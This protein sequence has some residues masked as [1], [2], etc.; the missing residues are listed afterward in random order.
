MQP[1]FILNNRPY[2]C[3]T[4]IGAENRQKR[5]DN[6]ILCLSR[7]ILHVGDGASF[8]HVRNSYWTHF[9]PARSKFLPLAA[10]EVLV[11]QLFDLL[12]P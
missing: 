10:P 12:Q 6:G 8:M 11:P 7:V 2:Y 1:E 9:G 5:D 4:I 3:D